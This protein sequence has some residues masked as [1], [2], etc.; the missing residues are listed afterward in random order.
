M[1]INN[2]L[3]LGIIILAFILRIYG[4]NWGLPSKDYYFSYN[5]DEVH[6]IRGLSQMDPKKLDFNPHYF[7]WG[8]WHYYE[9]GAII[10]LASFLNIV[11]LDKDK[12][13]YYSYP[14]EMAKIYLVG[15]LLSL[16][17]ALATVLLV[18]LIGK[19]I[20]GQNLG[21]LASFFMAINPA[22]II[23]SHYLKADTSVTFW[24]TL[25]LLTGIYLLKTGDLKWYI[26]SG[27]FSG[28]AMGSQQSGICFVHTI[29]LAHLLKEYK[30][31][32]NFENIK[33]TLLSRKLWTGYFV[34]FI[35]YLLTNP[36]LYLSTAEFMNG[37]I[38]SLLKRGRGPDTVIDKITI[39]NILGVFN[40]GLTQFFVFIGILGLFYG[41]MSKSKKLLLVLFW[42]LPYLVIMVII[43]ALNTR[44]QIL[45]YPG[46]FL[47]AAGVVQFFY[48]KI[49]FRYLRII[50]ILFITLFSFYTL[51][52]SYAY[53]KE[54]AK[55]KTIQ[56]EASEWLIFNIPAKTKIG[57]PSSP[58]I[59]HYPTIIHQDYYYKENSRYIIINLNSN[60]N[61][62]R[63][64]QPQYLILNEKAA[65]YNKKE[66]SVKPSDDFMK[67]IR[68]TYTIVKI[69]ERYPTFLLFS[70]KAKTLIP[71]WEMPF[72]VIYIL[73]KRV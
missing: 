4:I 48:T 30:R 19:K 65:F 38:F 25:L 29:L 2:I 27:I 40:V 63:S 8:T 61:N 57:I 32:F 59:R 51:I 69:F 34:V 20:Y 58:E 12:Y 72:P 11:K 22:H 70:F 36:S 13:F 17:F 1:K 45:V 14:W 52:Y 28:L 53:D 39:T 5:S 50:L 16:I 66:D 60:V 68:A 10:G 24:I 35:T 67:E 31:P 43:R 6:Y 55:E 54:L 64:E 56:Q 37:N 18:Y 71:D 41:A 46:L 15:R 42:L 9:L 33:H 47:L 3:F 23:N 44:Y 49:K 7:N 21:L 73:E 26:L 62:L